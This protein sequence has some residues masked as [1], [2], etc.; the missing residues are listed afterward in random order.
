MKK[1]LALLITIIMTAGIQAFAGNIEILPT[2]A[3]KSNAQDRVWVG[4]FQLVWNDF[5][6]KIVFNPIRFRE[7]NPVIVN[8]L[9]KQEF[10]ANDLSENSYYKY[11]GKVKKNTKK[12]ISKAIRKKFKETSDILDKLDLTPRN[13]MFVLYAMLKKDFEFI[14]EFDK[15]EH[16]TF[17]ENS[18][19][20]YFGIDKNSNPS[21]GQGVKVLFYNNS[22]DFAVELI[23]KNNDEVYLYK[24]S[25][26]KPFKYI[27]ADMLKK[28]A[29]FF[30]DKNFKK[31]DELKVPNIK[32]FEEKN[33]EEL[34]NRRIMGTNM[35]INQAIETIKF[36]M[37]N[38]GVKLKSEAAMTVMTTA[39]LPSEEATPRLFYFDDTFVIFLK[40][41]KKENP[42]FA[43]RV[44][45]I[46]KF[47]D[48]K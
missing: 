15:L 17:G 36:D 24:N 5:I 4:T 25:S 10:T 45:D 18:F 39:L 38:K 29:K 19:A 7:G 9:N 8:N 34:A 31:V 41:T 14:R 44:N 2:F 16:S 35:V 46:T 43:L 6:N 40:E 28:Q 20:N 30:G 26:N 47:Q 23:T 27:Y 1:L 3:S 33:F 21:L 42:Y 13:D 12:Q 11:A 32:F 48:N 22:D 37:N